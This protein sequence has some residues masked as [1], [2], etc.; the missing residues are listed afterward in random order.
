MKKLYY[1]VGHT[2]LKVLGRDGWTR[3][4]DHAMFFPT[5]QDAFDAM[6]QATLPGT[7]HPKNT[8]ICPTMSAGE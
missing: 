2:G 1:V 6:T 4:F 5:W 8:E 7:H 3:R